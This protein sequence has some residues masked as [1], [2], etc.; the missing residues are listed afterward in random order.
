MALALA[1]YL[2]G[3]ARV[4][5]GPLLAGTEMFLLLKSDANAEPPFSGYSEVRDAVS[6][7]FNKI[8]D[9]ADIDATLRDLDE[10]ANKINQEAAP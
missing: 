4:N 2:I 7:A 9:G 10:E 5:G 1:I 6:A 8:L 3:K